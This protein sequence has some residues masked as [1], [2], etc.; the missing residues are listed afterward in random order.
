[1]NQKLPSLPER[2]LE[3]GLYL[4]VFKNRITAV[5]LRFA[6]IWP[7]HPCGSAL[8]GAVQ[9]DLI[10]ADTQMV[11]IGPCIGGVLLR[12]FM[13]IVQCGIRHHIRVQQS[14]F[15]RIFQELP[16]FFSGPSILYRCNSVF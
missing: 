8:R 5:S 9:K 6:F 12:Q 15:C 14:L 1:M 13:G 16:F 10:T 11:A 3:I 7:A 2:R 4:F